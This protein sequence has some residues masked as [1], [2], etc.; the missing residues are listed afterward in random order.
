M[1]ILLISI[2]NDLDII[3]LKYLHYYLLK[4]G[5]N[6]F[7]L[8]LPNFNSSDDNVFKN[9]SKFVLEIDPIFIGISLI[10]TEYYNARDLTIYLKNNFKSIPVIWGGVHPTISPEMCLDY[11]DYVCIGEGERTI[12]DLANAVNNNESVKTINNLCYI[13]NDQIKKNMYNPLQTCHPIR[14]KVAT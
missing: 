4:N 10:S 7:L 13:E 3:G 12:L 9:I 1:N 5:Y 2:Q 11:A 8:Y 14:F 6:S